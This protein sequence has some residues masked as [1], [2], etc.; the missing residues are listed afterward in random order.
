M[1]S[2]RFLFS[3]GL[4]TALIVRSDNL[5]KDTCHLK[6][7]IEKIEIKMQRRLYL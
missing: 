1:N 5:K 7:I 4:K 3:L 6:T 2:G